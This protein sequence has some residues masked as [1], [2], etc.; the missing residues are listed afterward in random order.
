[1]SAP[2]VD[3]GDDQIRLTDA[4]SVLIGA[5]AGLW[6]VFSNTSEAR[7]GKPD[8]LDRWSKRVLAEVA[9]AHRTVEQGACRGSVVIEIQ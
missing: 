3:W 2:V 1:M 7:D 6:P 5:D 8:P 9:E 4:V